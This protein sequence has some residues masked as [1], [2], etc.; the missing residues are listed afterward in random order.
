M[1]RVA[2]INPVSG[3]SGDMCLG[4]LVDVGADPTELLRTLHSLEIPE[5]F[6]IDFY[7]VSR[8][9]ISALYADVRSASSVTHRSLSEVFG[10]LDG[11]G[12]T[13][14]QRTLAKKIFS[15][16]AGAEAAVHN[17]SIEEVDLHEVGSLDAILDICGFVVAKDLLKIEKLYIA[18]P[19]LGRGL[20]QGAHGKMAVPAPAVVQLLLGEEVYG[21]VGDFELTTPTGAAIIST[22]GIFSKEIPKMTI[23][24]A[25][26]GAGTKD[27]VD[28]ANVL[29]LLLGEIE[30]VSVAEAFPPG[31]FEEIVELQTNLDDVTGEVAGHLISLLM[32]KG[33][34]DVFVTPV[35]AKKHRPAHLLTV[36]TYPDEV[37]QM[38]KVI[39][40]ETG[41]LGIRSL[42]KTRYVL[43]RGFFEI[44]LLGESVLV[45]EGP[46]RAKPEF[47]QLVRLAT[48]HE[49]PL[50]HVDRMAQVEITK[51]LKAR[52]DRLRPENDHDKNRETFD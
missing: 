20:A 49:L 31:H 18:P 35:N 10:I 51:Y 38:S 5:K 8:R 17:S 44:Q 37:V 25:G 47:E 11:S 39:F 4:A 7:R 3:I 15:N 9:G 21:G 24:G 32:G 45:K 43:D 12:L 33:A 19:A 26:Y 27:P 28:H 29:Q 14:D 34:I 22:L 42:S 30:E 41:T 13:D 48:K 46:Y 6:E 52:P 36:V 2:W 40:G 23:I 1:A 16:L 50:L